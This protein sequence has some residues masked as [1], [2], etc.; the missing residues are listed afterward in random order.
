ME[1]LLTKL[2]IR[3]LCLPSN[4]NFENI[5]NGRINMSKCVCDNSNHIACVFQSYKNNQ[6]IKCVKLWNK[7]V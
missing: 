5:L 2:C 4:I 6:C 1:S 7:Y 3:R